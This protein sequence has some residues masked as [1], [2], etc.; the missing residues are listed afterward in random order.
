MHIHL[1]SLENAM[2]PF[3]TG[4]FLIKM[5]QGFRDGREPRCSGGDRGVENDR[6][7]KARV[8]LKTKQKYNLTESPYENV[9]TVKFKPLEC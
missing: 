6:E 5:L 3:S 8:C 4:H 9:W 1:Y 7:E 2:V